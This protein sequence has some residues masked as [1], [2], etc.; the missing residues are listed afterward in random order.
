[1]SKQK[2]PL[3]AILCD[4]HPSMN[5]RVVKEADSLVSA[6]FSVI[7]LY[8]SLTPARQIEDQ[9][10]LS[11]AR[12][13]SYCY[14]NLIHDSR[15]AWWRLQRK[16][17]QYILRLF[18]IVL[19]GIWGHA[20]Y[21]LLHILHRLNPQLIIGHR[22]M[23]L[24]ALWKLRHHSSV[25][26][27]DIEDWMSDDTA[28]LHWCS[29]QRREM[30]RLEQWALRHCK[31]RTTTSDVLAHELSIHYSC[32]PPLTIT[33][34]F[35]DKLAPIS[36]CWD[37]KRPLRLHWFSQTIGPGR[38]L[39][40]IFE[41]LSYFT[42][43]SIELHL[44]GDVPPYY[45][46]WL[47]SATTHLDPR[48]IIIHPRISPHELLSSMYS[49][50]IGLALELCSTRSRSLT[51]TNKIFQYM[52]AG[53]PVIAT[54]TPGQREVIQKVPGSGWLIS[55]TDNTVVSLRRILAVIIQNPELLRSASDHARLLPSTSI[56]HRTQR[57]RMIEA[58]HKALSISNI[59]LN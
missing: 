3:I 7:V 54:D 56:G 32:L 51:S 49:Y 55:L 58:V 42:H 36:T 48:Q 4:G 13:H 2:P 52:E 6:G 45:L 29:V 20:P 39:E 17:S 11:S 28:S 33:N 25:K 26:G 41:A 9:E 47:S 12:W 43:D 23:G 22:E 24:W 38:G 53:L 31:F 21:R 15:A 10:I 16:V 34:S 50:D 37:G 8:Q 5:P 40:L 46:S 14:A 57:I 44:R 30:A 27:C 35:T 1:M 18:G 59:E 19:P